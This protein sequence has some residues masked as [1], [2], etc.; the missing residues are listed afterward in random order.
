[1]KFKAFIFGLLVSFGLPWLLVIVVPFSAMRSLEPAKYAGMEIDGGDG[2]Y[3]PKRD[4]RIKEGSEVYGQEGC[5]YCHT[6]LIRPTYAGS[7][8]WRADW[9]GL[10]KSADNPDTRRETLATDYEGEKIAHI[11]VMRVGHD[12]SNLGRR[13][14]ANLKG[15]QL[16]PETWTFLHLYNPRGITPYRKDSQD[17]EER[18]A[19]PSKPSLFKEVSKNIAGFDALPVAA[20]E[21]KAIIPSD[22]ARALV[23]YLVSLKKDT[24]E[25]PVPQN[26]NY[27]PTQ[28]AAQ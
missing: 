4:G 9:A 10:K 25:Q 26:L 7:D 3:I 12:L 23:S 13:L 11:G 14:E 1:M 17:R 20:P 28:P 8:V 6:Q 15:T 2:V 16:S 22:R 5:Y 24:L 18:S 21:G 27:N 19:C